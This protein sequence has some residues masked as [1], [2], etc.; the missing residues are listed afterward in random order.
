MKIKLTKKENLDTI[1]IEFENGRYLD[2]I[3]T[4][5]ISES[6]FPQIQPWDFP[7]QLKGRML[8]TWLYWEIIF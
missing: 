8:F 6:W 2:I 5:Y 3:S 7:G 1:K 4:N